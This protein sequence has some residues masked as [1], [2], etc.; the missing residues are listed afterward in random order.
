MGMRPVD[1]ELM[2]P[3]TADFTPFAT[4]LS[5]AKPDWIWSWTAWDL[6]VA[7]FEA[8][9]RLGW[10]GRF[11]A[12]SHIQAEDTLAGVKDPQFFTIG[13]NSYFF[14]GLPVQKEI[15]ATAAA[16]GITYAA[17]RLAEGW[18]AG[19]T[20]E[21]T[22][23]AAGKDVT[24]EQIASVM[25]TLTIDTRGLRGGPIEWSKDNHFRKRQSYRVHRW[26]GKTLESVGDWRHYEVK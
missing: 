14:E 26:N 11:L 4:K 1:K 17:S 2:P 21:A 20:I 7:T 13:T 18:I 24:P 9:R 10:S 23:K 19:M 22:F 15:A 3:A 8:T 5:A 6:Q 25:E 12:W 16:A